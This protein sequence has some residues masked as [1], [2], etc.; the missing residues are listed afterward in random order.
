MSQVVKGGVLVAGVPEDDGVDDR[1][2]IFAKTRPEADPAVLSAVREA[3]ADSP[4][5]MAT[6]GLSS[7]LASGIR[8]MAFSCPRCRSVFGEMFLSR[9]WSELSYGGLTKTVTAPGQA[10]GAWHPHY[11]IDT[12]T[13]NC[14]VPPPSLLAAE[15]ETQDALDARQ[16]AQTTVTPVATISARDAIR[17]RFGSSFY[18]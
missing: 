9:F 5:P 15:Q 4:T 16:V 6:I 7:T 2:T 11:C 10:A 3:V 17:R 13:G 18:R 8:Y 12:G 1:D 14:L